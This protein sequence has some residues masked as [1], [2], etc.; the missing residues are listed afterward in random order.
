M[1]QRIYPA[2]RTFLVFLFLY[3]L[4]RVLK[5]LH[6]LI[7]NLCISKQTRLCSLCITLCLS[8]FLSLSLT[9]LA[10]Y[11]LLA[12]LC[13]ARLLGCKIEEHL[14]SIKLRQLLHLCILFKIVSKTQK[15]NL[16]LL[17]KQD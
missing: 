2:L 16:A 15:Q 6:S 14:L 12:F 3:L 10:I 8:S 11:F 7:A 13:H 17:F 1:W 9:L 5:L 4:F